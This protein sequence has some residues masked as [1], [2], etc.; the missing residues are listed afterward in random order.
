MYPDHAQGLVCLATEQDCLQHQD[1][2]PVQG[3]L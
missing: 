1:Y 2:L 3:F